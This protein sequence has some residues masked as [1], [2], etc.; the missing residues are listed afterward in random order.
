MCKKWFTKKIHRKFKGSYTIVIV[1]DN[2][3]AFITSFLSNINVCISAPLNP[4]YTTSKFYFYIK[5]LIPT[6]LITNFND[7]HAALTVTKKNTIKLIN[8]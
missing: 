6:A 3:P 8:I 5:Y 4:H 7:Y 2:G 1:L